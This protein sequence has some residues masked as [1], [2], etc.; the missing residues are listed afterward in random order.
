MIV[1]DACFI[2]PLFVREDE[3]EEV[4]RVYDCDAHWVAPPLWRYELQNILW[5]KIRK[6]IVDEADALSIVL[7]AE[8]LV[9]T[10]PDFLPNLTLKT[11]ALHG[12]SAYDAT[13]VALAGYLNLPL[14]TYDKQVLAAGL[15][16][17]PRDFLLLMGCP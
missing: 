1:V 2:T 16:T 11:A 6:G 10:R 5:K 14:V 15:G 7:E 9:D 8:A 3:S 4:E 13:Y 12:L 17:H